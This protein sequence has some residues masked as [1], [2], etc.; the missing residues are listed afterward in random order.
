MKWR[1]S[2]FFAAWLGCSGSLVGC[3]ALFGFEPLE[4]AEQVPPDS[5][6]PAPSVDAAVDATTPL[7]CR[8][9]VTVSSTSSQGPRAVRLA[10]DWIGFTER[11]PGGPPL[12]SS[13]GYDLDG[14][15]T[16]DEATSPCKFDPRLIGSQPDQ[17]TDDACGVDNLGAAV[18]QVLDQ[19]LGNTFGT[20]KA[21]QRI[22]EGWAGSLLDLGNLPLD[23]GDAKT[24]VVGWLPLWNMLHT[25]ADGSVAC[26]P[27]ATLDSGEP[28]PPQPEEVW[29]FDPRFADA[30]GRPRLWGTGAI[31]DHELAVWIRE[32][33][34]PLTVGELEAGPLGISYL[35]IHDALITGTLQRRADG[36]IELRDGILAGKIRTADMLYQVTSVSGCQFP[37][38]AV[39]Q[40][41]GSLC[42]AREAIV[43]PQSAY[44]DAI[45]VALPFSA[46]EVAEPIRSPHTIPAYEYTCQGDGYPQPPAGAPDCDRPDVLTDAGPLVP[47]DASTDASDASTDAS[48]TADP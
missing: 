9:P 36:S 20:R 31:T 41:N 35:H 1:K 18:F 27:R 37:P 14:V 2:V 47:S 46:H 43:D 8:K 29:C 15:V 10:F 7:S 44:C 34:V 16:V 26:G 45:S 5:A 32:V 30:E 4:E 17:L 22:R 11:S 25:E 23:D 3:A 12:D 24:V 13:F 48:D 19:R 39:E 38:G 42:Y 21:A 28:E 40:L 6:A 33:F